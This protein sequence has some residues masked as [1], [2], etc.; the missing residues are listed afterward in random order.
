MSIH[1]CYVGACNETT[2]SSRKDAA[3]NRQRILDAASEAFAEH[4]LDV[5]LNDVAAYAGVGVG[6]VY[7]RFANKEALI[8]ALFEQRLQDIA[9]A[10]Q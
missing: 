6:T 4:G 1:L 7:R 3:L 2:A 10:A 8:D 9:A 5:T